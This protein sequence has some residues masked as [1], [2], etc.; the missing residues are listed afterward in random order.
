MKCKTCGTEVSKFAR[1][2]SNCGT[3]IHVTVKYDYLDSLAK[4]GTTK[5][6]KQDRKVSANEPVLPNASKDGML[7]EEIEEKV[8]F[9]AILKKKKRVVCALVC[10]MLILSVVGMRFLLTRSL[11]LGSELYFYISGESLMCYDEKTETTKALAKGEYA[12]IHLFSR[13]IAG[14]SSWKDLIYSVT[15][16]SNHMVYFGNNDTDGNIITDFSIS[17]TLGWGFHLYCIEMGSQSKPVQI[18]SSVTSYQILNDRY[19]LYSKTNDSGNTYIYDLE[20]KISIPLYLTE[21]I[22]AISED[23]NYVLYGGEESLK[24]AQ[25]P[26][27]EDKMEISKSAVSSCKASKDLKTIVYLTTTGELHVLTDFKKDELIATQVLEYNPLFSEGEFEVYYTKGESTFYSIYDLVNDD[28]Y[29]IDRNMV[30]PVLEEGEDSLDPEYR[31]EKEAYGNKKNRDEKRELMK[32]SYF[33]EKGNTLYYYQDGS[34]KRILD[35]VVEVNCI[36]NSS[37]V[38]SLNAFLPICEVESNTG[39]EKIDITWEEDIYE[40]EEKLNQQ[41]VRDGRISHKYLLQGEER[42]DLGDCYVFANN[43]EEQYVSIAT[44]KSVGGEY[45]LNGVKQVSY[46]KESFGE[47]IVN[48]ETIPYGHEVELIDAAGIIL[49]NES[50]HSGVYYNE[51]GSIVLEG[52]LNGSGKKAENDNTLYY[53]AKDRDGTSLYRLEG[54]TISKVAEQVGGFYPVDSKEVFVLCKDQE[55]EEGILYHY[56]KD[57][58]RE[59]IS[60][61]VNLI[62]GVNYYEKE[63]DSGNMYSLD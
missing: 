4:K 21:V 52:Y 37:D 14:N 58:E 12:S 42:I 49:Y 6:K 27:L 59:E 61:H 39:M 62:S 2:C 44:M 16:D 26:T 45:Q 35:G 15:P 25:L 48:Q 50:F 11:V 51:K 34:S 7:E 41:N 3:A 28:L 1:V 13:L 19:V 38:A 46:G 8:P 5:K 43:K 18:S 63:M 40:I 32:N 36:P 47:Y 56:N 10:G 31:V 53:M 22:Q 30:E 33:L 54:E 9:L 17:S 23:G 57:G 24:I 29:E 60:N 55:S 20:Q